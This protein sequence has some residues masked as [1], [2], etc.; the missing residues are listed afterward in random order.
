MK[1]SIAILVLLVMSATIGYTQGPPP[2]YNTTTMEKKV[3]NKIRRTMR[4]TD[5]QE[6]VNE[7]EKE[8]FIVTCLVNDEN[9]VEVSK[10]SGLDKELAEDITSTLEK[11]PVKCSED[12]KGDYFSFKLT[13]EHRPNYR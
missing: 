3:L 8:S 9:I 2:V 7:G 6:Y 4:A 1:K 11:H 5:F 12:K 10:I 13:F